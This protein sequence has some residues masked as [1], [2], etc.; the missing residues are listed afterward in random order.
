MKIGVIKFLL[1]NGADGD[2]RFR[3]HYKNRQYVKNSHRPKTGKQ[4]QQQGH[5]S[6]PEHGKIEIFRKAPANTEYHAVSG[7]VDPAVLSEFV[8]SS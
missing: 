5:G 2:D 4:E 1:V 3:F 8:E 6:D 7:A